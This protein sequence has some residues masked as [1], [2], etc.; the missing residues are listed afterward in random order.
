M[1]FFQSDP[2]F[3]N[4]PNAAGAPG[5]GGYLGLEDWGRG[6]G[7]GKAG[8]FNLGLM[9]DMRSGAYSGVAGGL[10]SPIHDRF[11]TAGREAERNATM[12]GNA[13]YRGTQPALM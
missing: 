4:N 6:L 9:K 11:A 8:K 3:M 12:G 5:Q 13:M 7:I 1:G 10:L 2:K